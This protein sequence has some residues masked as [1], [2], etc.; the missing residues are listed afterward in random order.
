MKRYIILFLLSSITL[1]SSGQ[2]M[3][4]LFKS[5]PSE[6]LPAFSEA[7]KTMLLVDSSL[8]VI[9]YALGE[10]ERLDYTDTF[11]SL[12]TSEVGTMQIKI[13]PLVNKTKIIALIK[14]VCSTVCNSNIQ[15]FTS[16]WEE[17]EKSSL[18]PEIPYY[19]FFD[20]TKLE[21]P[22]F[23]W[24]ISKIDMYPLQF[25]FKDGGSDLQVKLD[26]NNH[27]SAQDSIT[28]KPYLIKETIDLSWNKS[29]FVY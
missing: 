3:N 12:K 5:M 25:Q 9:P 8:S 29:T 4:E 10:I 14:T 2:T 21:T 1:L 27:L 19:T 20:S 15:F 17:V 6:Y 28:I 23:K 24:A 26:I 22:E 11:L 16:E 13:L 18:L 7:N